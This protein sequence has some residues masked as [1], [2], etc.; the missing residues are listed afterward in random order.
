MDDTSPQPEEPEESE[1]SKDQT[2]PIQPGT[3]VLHKGRR[4]YI[5]TSESHLGANKAHWVKFDTYLL[6]PEGDL[7]V[8]PVQNCI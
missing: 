5:I 3:Y 2:L 6:I 7:Q 8:D 4:G 1:E